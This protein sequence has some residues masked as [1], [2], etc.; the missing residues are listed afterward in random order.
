MAR[1]NDVKESLPDYVKTSLSARK[2]SESLLA[3]TGHPDNEPIR[4]A[5]DFDNY[6]ADH[7]DGMMA[8]WMTE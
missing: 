1:L 4:S 8:A 5:E 3:S 7:N 2:Q 6:M